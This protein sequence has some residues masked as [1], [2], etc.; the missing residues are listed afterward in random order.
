MLFPYANVVAG[1][2]L[3]L[4]GFGFHFI[5]QLISLVDWDTAIRLGLQEKTAPPDYYPYEHGTAVAD[6][7]IGWTYPI[8]AIGLI[9]NLEWAYTLAWFPG[10]ILLYHSLNSWFWEADRRAAGH[11]LQ[12]ETFRVVWCGGNFVTGLLTILVASN[13]PGTA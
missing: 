9:M 7:L 13:G 5:G 12:S 3:L 4:I 1:I 10:V 2:L 11:R 6:V 8:A